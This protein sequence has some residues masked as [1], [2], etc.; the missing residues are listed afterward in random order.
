MHLV[1]NMLADEYVWM[2]A[3]NTLEREHNL[4][5]KAFVHKLIN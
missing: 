3:Y 4:L 1:F 5:I 2:V